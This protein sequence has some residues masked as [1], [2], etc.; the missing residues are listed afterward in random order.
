MR[1]ARYLPGRR[2]RRPT[3]AF[4]PMRL[5][6]DAGGSLFGRA[7]GTSQ[8]RPHRAGRDG[9]GGAPSTG[10]SVPVSGMS[11]PCGILW[12]MDRPPGPA[13]RSTPD[14]VAVGPSASTEGEL[15]ALSAALREADRAMAR[16]V[17][18]AGQLDGRRAAAEEGMTVDGALQLHTGAARSDVSMVLTAGD[19]LARMP[20]TAGLFAAGVLSWGHVRTLVAGVRRLDT[21][22]RATL[23]DHLGAQADRLAAM[24]PEQRLWAVDDAVA[25]CTPLRQLEDRTD[26]AV[27]AEF[28][29]IQGRLDG[30]GSA[31]GEF[32]P[33]SLATI[34]DALAAEADAPRA[35]P[36][37]G[38]QDGPA[39]PVPTRAQQLAAALVRLCAGGRRTSSG[40][41][42]VR[43]AVS[44]DLDQLTDTAAGT[45]D[46]GVRGR[47]PRLVRRAIERLAC[48]AALDVVLR[49]GVDLIAAQRY[50]PEVTA[51]ARR[52]VA[53]RD[54]GC[55]FPGCT[56]PISWCDLHHVEPRATGDDH[57]VANLI[58]LCRTHHTTVHR[59]G[60]R[61]HL[62]RDGTYLLRRRGRTWTTL[63]RRH[64]HLPPPEDH[65]AARDGPAPPAAAPPP[66]HP[67]PERTDPAQPPATH[68]PDLLPF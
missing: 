13:P 25:A 38:D 56:A 11:H 10:P 41:A 31:Y 63:P 54:G 43:F 51:A 42:P 36:C 19:V 8:V 6:G 68:Q 2:T 4:E 3:Q 47:P 18:L 46:A 67:P 23:D 20:A 12:G 27:E 30:S 7:P 49:D 52:A 22:A 35:R 26:R 5:V 24:E 14:T 33:E 40:S 29:A 37:P 53:A 50:A 55:R 32:G 62:H 16:A 45:I 15:A 64:Q 57:A 9:Q 44:V 17:T 39:Q 66:D 65:T 59:R 1:N 28:L 61:Q 21:T 48:D 34:T 58:S 60:W